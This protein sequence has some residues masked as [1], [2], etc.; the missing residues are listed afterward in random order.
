MKTPPR[1]GGVSLMM[2]T[3]WV[4]AQPPPQTRAASVTR[5]VLLGTGNPGIDPDRSGPATAVVV[6]DTPYLVDFGPGVVRRAKAA[7][8]G[9]GIKA[10]EPT[11][12]RVAFSALP[13]STTRR[14]SSWRTSR[15][16]LG[17]GC[18]SSITIRACRPKSC[19]TTCLRATRATL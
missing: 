7:V 6:N 14:R 5:V 9:R 16:R 12:L 19:W 4:A 8:L 1:V 13:P 11:N 18:S 3:A 15:G 2:L 17:R 10:L